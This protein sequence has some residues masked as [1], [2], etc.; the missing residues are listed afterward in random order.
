MGVNVIHEENVPSGSAADLYM[1]KV[2]TAAWASLVFATDPTHFDPP[3]LTA[4]DKHPKLTFLHAGGL[5]QEGK[6]PANAGSY[7]GYLDEAFYVCGVVAGMTTQTASWAS[8][9]AS[10][11]RSPAQ[12]Q[13]LR[14]GARAANPGVTTTVVFTGKWSND[15][16]EKKAAN[17]LA[18]KKIDV[19][20][21]FVKAPKTILET[22]ERRRDL[23]RGR[24]RRRASFAPKGYL[25]AAVSNWE[26]IYADYVRAVSRREALPARGARR[27]CQRLRQH[28]A[29]RPGGLRGGEEEGTWPCAPGSPTAASPS[30]RTAQEQRGCHGGSRWPRGHSE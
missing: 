8:S 5:Y 4:A 16:A 18:D 29:V 10:A 13:R 21:M 1:E 14:D 17:A 11:A 30:S 20:A 26:R 7:A 23:Q 22:A 24:A 27:D 28:R 19:L 12:H 9:P 6:H 3:V 15:E 25:T 2:V